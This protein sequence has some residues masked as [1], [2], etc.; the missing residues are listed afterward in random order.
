MLIAS[1]PNQPWRR[2][3][4]AVARAIFLMFMG[5]RKRGMHKHVCS[6]RTRSISPPQALPGLGQVPTPATITARKD[7]CGA[8]KEKRPAMLFYGREFY[9]DINV[10]AMSFE[11][12]CVYIR[13]L[14]LCWQ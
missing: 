5:D 4:P 9:E 3:L 7:R 2:A 12:Q 13:L 10:M 1:S 11:Q 14:W 6:G 8:V